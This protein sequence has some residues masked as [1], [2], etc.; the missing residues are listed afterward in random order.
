MFFRSL[1]IALRLFTMLLVLRKIDNVQEKMLGIAD[2]SE[3]EALLFHN[4]AHPE[5]SGPGEYL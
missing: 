4:L 5:H 3:I 2:M 1:S